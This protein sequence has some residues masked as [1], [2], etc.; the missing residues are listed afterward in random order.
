MWSTALVSPAF[1]L[2]P[3][4]A[5]THTRASTQ[6]RQLYKAVGRAWLPV[7]DALLEVIIRHLPS[8]DVAQKT[9]VDALYS[10]TLLL[11]LLLLFCCFVCV[12]VC[13]CVCLEI[14]RLFCSSRDPSALPL[15]TPPHYTRL[16]GPMN[17]EFAAAI[18]DCDPEGPLMVYISKLIPDSKGFLAYGR[19]FSG[20]AR[21]GAKVAT[22]RSFG[23]GVWGVAVGLSVF[24]FFCARVL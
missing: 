21:P 22:T 23:G 2:S 7:A 12:C 20:T 14:A 24:A 13:V 3:T 6:G 10:G 9:R 8:P 1:T 11:L 4:A 19:V 18:R 15:M 17:D 16:T 5:H